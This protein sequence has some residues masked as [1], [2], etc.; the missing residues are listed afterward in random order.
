MLAAM[1][2]E[3]IRVTVRTP[4]KMGPKLLLLSRWQTLY[5]P[6]V[7]NPREYAH[8][9]PLPSHFSHQFRDNDESNLL[10]VIEQG[11]YACRKVVVH[12]GVGAF[13]IRDDADSRTWHGAFVE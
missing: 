12:Q 7:V 13:R 10:V 8:L 1:R 9:V 5:L 6:W 2:F 4:E 3:E 11:Y